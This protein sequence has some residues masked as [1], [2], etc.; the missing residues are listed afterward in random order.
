MTQHTQLSSELIIFVTHVEPNDIYLKIWGQVDKQAATAVEHYIG[1]LIEQFNQGYGC[2]SKGSRLISGTLCCARFQSDGYFRAKILSVRPDGM[3]VVQFIDYGNVEIL[4]PTEIHLLDNIHGSEPLRAYPAMAAEFTLINILPVNGIWEN[5]TIE[6][7]KK[8]LCYNEYRA[9]VQMMHNHC[10]IKLWYNNGDFSELLVKEHMAL[11]ATLQDM[12][13]PK[14]TLQPRMLQP[15]QMPVYQQQNKGNM[16]NFAPMPMM[17]NLNMNHNVNMQGL[18]HKTFSPDI[19]QHKHVAHSMS[20]HP[21]PPPIQEALVF[22][23]RVLDVGS[24]HEVLISHVEDGPQ[25]FSVQIESMRAVLTRLMSEINNRSKQPL[26]EPPLPGSVCLG[27]HKDSGDGVLCRA[28]VMSVMEHKCK[29]YYVDF[30]HTEVLPYTD[31]FQLPPE[32]INPKVLSIRFTLSGLKELNITLEMKEYFKELVSGK[33]LILHVRPPEGPP[34]IQYGDLYENGVNVKEMLKKAFP[35]PTTTTPIA[36]SYPQLRRLSKDF[37]EVVSVS[38]VESYDKFFVQLDSGAKSLESIMAGLAQYAK[39]ASALNIAQLRAGLPCAALYDS[40]WYRAQILGIV[41]DKIKV[42]YVDY[43]NEEILPVISLRAIH[44][45]LVTKLPA[46]AIKCALNGHEVLSPDQE[47][48][49]RFE[50][51]TLE[52]RLHMKVVAVQPTNLL[53]DLFE[54]D[55]MRS[56]Q[57]QLLNNLFCDTTENSTSSRN[58]EV[59]PV[60][61]ISDFHSENKDR[62]D[63]KDSWN[64]SQ[65]TKSF[66]DNKS[67]AWKNEWSPE[68][69]HDNR[70]EK[71]SGYFHRDGSQNDRFNKDK[72][73][74]RFNRDKSYNK[75]DENDVN[76]YNRNSR[77][78]R[79]G[80]SKFTGNERRYNRNNAN[81]TVCS[82]KDSD[83]SSKGNDRR[84]KFGFKRNSFNNERGG[85]YDGGASSKSHATNWD[86]KKPAWRSN[87]NERFNGDYNMNNNK[88]RNK[89]D[90][91]NNFSHDQIIAESWDTNDVNKEQQNSVDKKSQLSLKNI[92]IALTSVKNCEVVFIN[93]PS[94]FFI[95]LSPDCLELNPIMESIAT[96]YE[97]G[98]E[99]MQTSEIQS[100]T[101]CIA[102]YSEDLKW[103]RAVI[104]SVEENSATVEFVDYGNTESVDF[105]NI[106]VILE[107]FLKLPMQAVHCKLLG[108]ANIDNQENQLEIFSEKAEGKSLQ[109]E[110]VAEEN[111]I[112]EVLLCEVV[113]S[114]PNT[115]YINEEFCAIADL[116]KA[117]QTAASKK[118]T[119]A[120]VTETKIVDYAPLD[121]KWQTISCE[122]ESKQNVIITWFINPNKFFCQLLSK[123]A[124]FSAMMSE[125]QKIYANR[126]SVSQKLQIGSAIIAKF[127][128]DGA[129]YRAEVVSN[130]AKDA[131]VVQ[132]IDF[133]NC[134]IVYRDN[135]YPVEKKFMQLPKLAVQCS[136]KDI[137]PNNNNLS[138]SEVD[139]N[140]LDNCFNADKYECIFHSLNDN[141]YIISLNYN[142]QDVNNMLIERNLATIATKTLVETIDETSNTEV[143][144]FNNI[145]RV[146]ISL[147]SGQTLKMRISDVKSTNQ[148]YVQLPSASRCENIVDQYMT[149]KNPKVMPRLSTRELCLGAGCLVSIH[150]VW[151]RAVVINCTRSVGFDIKLIDTGTYDEILN[152]ALALPGELAVMQNQA[153][154]CS[155]QNTSSIDADKRLKEFEGKEILVYV[156]EVN[157]SRLIVKL[158]DLVGNGIMNIEEKILPICPMPILSSTHE[159]IPTYADHSTNIWLRRNS[160]AELET[161]LLE[162]LQQ[163]YTNSGQKLKPEEHLLCAA[164]STYDGQWYRAKIIS[165]TKTM[166]YVSYIDYGNDED[167]PL[168]SI[169]ILEPQFYE[170]YQLAVKVSLS[171]SFIGTEA[172]QINIL[173]TYLK[174]KTFT[175]VFYNVRKK[176]IVDLIEN[177]EKLSDKLRSLNLVKTEQTE[178][179]P[180]SQIGETSI[181]GRFD[182]C[183]SHVDSPSQFW[184]Q[185]TDKI[186]SLNEKQEQLQ[187][188][189]PN[190]STIDGIP[191]EGTLCIASYSIDNLWYRAE[192]LDADEDITTIRF[193][194]YG[195]TDVID[196]KTS[197]IRQIPDTWKNL[198]I[199]ALKCRLDI[200]PVDTEDWSES[201][202]ERFR[203]LVMSAETL[204][205]QIVADTMPKRVELFID[206][207]SVSETLVEEKH[208]IIINTEQEPVDEIVDLELDPHSAFVCHVNS[209]SE[210]WVQEEKSVADLEVMADRFMV[211]D[212]FPKIDDIKEGLLC[213]AKYPE[214]E[215]WYRARVVSHDENGTQ[216]IYIDYGNSAVSTEIRTIPEDLASIPPL[217]RKCCLELPSQIKEWSEQAREEFVKL[218]ADGA[219]IF[220]LDVLK[221]QETSLVKLTLDGQNV[222]D[223]LGDMCEQ[224]APVIDERLPPLGEENS[225]NVMISHINSPSEFWIQAESS[226][227]ELEVMSDRLRDAESFLTLNNL[228]IGT[229]CAA[230]YPEDGFWY[231][232]KI[233]AHCEKGTEVLYMDYGNSA[234]TEELRML[235]EDIV[236]IPT[237]SKR[238]ALEKPNNIIAWS[239]EACDKFRELA[240][241]GATM[242]QFET[243]DENDPMHVRLS[244]NGTNVIDLLSTD[245]KNIPEVSEVTEK[246]KTATL[247]NEQEPIFN[248]TDNLEC[249]NK[250]EKLDINE[251]LK[252][253]VKNSDMNEKCEHSEKQ[254]SA[255][256][257][258]SEFVAT[259]YI[260]KI[261]DNINMTE[262]DQ[263][264]N[265]IT[266]Q[267]VSLSASTSITS[268]PKAF[269]STVKEL[270][271]DEIIENMIRDA[272]D[273]LE[274]QKVGDENVLNVKMQQNVNVTQM[275]IVDR[276]EQQ[277]LLS[278][279]QS[280]DINKSLGTQILETINTRRDIEDL[281]SK[282]IVT[283]TNGSQ[284]VTQ[285]DTSQVKEEEKDMHVEMESDINESSKSEILKTRLPE[286][287]IKLKQIKKQRPTKNGTIP[288]STDNNGI[289][290]QSDNADL[291][292]DSSSGLTC[293]VKTT[294]SSSLKTDSVERCSYSEKQDK[295]YVSEDKPSE[296]EMKRPVTPKTPHSEKIV[297]AVVNPYV[298][299]VLDNTSENDEILNISIED[300]I[301]KYMV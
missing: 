96:T 153:L 143:Q 50:Q 243:L 34:L 215:Q 260:S 242:F 261:I 88:F 226:I 250:M 285:L 172:E 1:P 148:F 8:I 139:N 247:I 233:V 41:G 111:G 152:D 287:Q 186:A 17:Q 51:L 100:G 174:I 272:T 106:K 45:D 197:S 154:E 252:E 18:Y 169:M 144:A 286:E 24:D 228:D 184:L 199:F 222:A 58:G 104:K 131:Y 101:Y 278:Q 208:A 207:K 55:T 67:N 235:P 244:L 227:S 52:K 165:Y 86:G 29:L 203:N 141:Q 236:N 185:Y 183:V 282:Q 258:D 110:F 254:Q 105:T 253:S 130:Y 9:L 91:T 213:V 264:P 12:F 71:T 221:E 259:E 230:R 102:Q 137:V 217:S 108:L 179:E 162:D 63:K 119:E 127:S 147:L 159:V 204:Q 129:L 193:I 249:V 298:Q 59:E 155:L 26:Q 231:R 257:N 237:L 114:V 70:R 32:Y 299:S 279:I 266:D 297:A 182:V 69:Q 15:L 206:N 53:V 81:D 158:Y 210:F 112:Y 14:H 78:T 75:Y 37:Q 198:E 61:A 163:Y 62:Y 68:K 146:D 124:E 293:T 176:W 21:L 281:E 173:Q 122:S 7:I 120:F 263:D 42:V 170:P 181:P 274:S 134:A 83:T 49:N 94:D 107:E 77:G 99:T 189:V 156:E 13:R 220:L 177:G 145:E 288:K 113:D 5:R 149:D 140:A 48:L 262:I 30:G 56:I 280:I 175:A 115:N 241:D 44:D 202:C 46:Q 214:D 82:D 292:N 93:S 84:G 273:D 256:S 161:K 142:G 300:N 60:K 301:P 126:E 40:Q 64:H 135:I 191:E 180:L 289:E 224:Q 167:I 125:I 65:N 33:L 190:F 121:S 74:N 283:V 245:Y 123:E 39:T 80:G 132:Y 54:Y 296:S 73:N 234:V 85:N 212:M 157:N 16:N 20:Q 28:V 171:V 79:D 76:T 255:T 3:I 216:V 223:I 2:P 66:Q 128:E 160:D 95:Q 229:I 211:A 136:L 133:G 43:G 246:M 38:Y 276:N 195:N 150:G 238:C 10:L 23:S 225:P 117:K 103:Y 151:K 251:A 166:V 19:N 31:I 4:P 27:R 205:V 35:S 277:K 97:T 269:S 248:Q 218:A 196:N 188:E 11:P 271:V 209:P 118:A 275:K 265:I 22:K 98:G 270:S 109:V 295:E 200:I 187:L 168:E 239:E 6:R 268:S 291:S 192:V 201:T 90:N 47:I 36:Y 57:L 194:D 164:K 72:A 232:S 219:T 138:W 240:A 92:D 290:T 178:S 116:I 25:K 294:E 284:D 87:R 267:I 89:I